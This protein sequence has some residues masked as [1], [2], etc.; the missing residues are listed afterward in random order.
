MA[1]RARILPSLGRLPEHDLVFQN[2]AVSS[3]CVFF[4]ITYRF[5]VMA[6]LGRWAVPMT[7]SALKSVGHPE[8]IGLHFWKVTNYDM[9]S[10]TLSFCL[11]SQI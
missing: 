10:F 2:V 9:F 6:T 8:T 7:R 11:A 4:V 1:L 5:C 3:F